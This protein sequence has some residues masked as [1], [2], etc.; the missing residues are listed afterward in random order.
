MP[1]DTASYILGQ[2]AGGGGGSDVT[3]EALDVTEN[4]TTT[5]PSG[6]AY[7]PVT[8]NVPNSYGAGDEGKVVSNG[9]LVAQ[10]AH[11]EVT[12][13]GT[14]DTTLNNSVTVNVSDGVD[15]A[16]EKDVNFIDY[17]GTLLYSYT[18]AEAQALTAL[19]A[20][21]SHSGLTAQGWNWTLQEIKAQ[22]T[23]VPGGP[24]WVGQMYVTT[25]GAT[26]IDIT[27]QSDA[28]L[29]YLQIGVNGTTT[30]DWGD[31]SNRDTVSGTGV[32]TIQ[33][34]PH[35]YARAGNYT[36]SIS[37]GS[38]KL[39]SG[40]GMAGVLGIGSDALHKS[41]KYSSCITG[42]RT[43][44]ASEASFTNYALQFCTSMRYVTLPNNTNIPQAFVGDCF[45]IRALVCPAS[46]TGANYGRFNR[47]LHRISFG[48]ALTMWGN[49]FC[50][51]TDSL[52]SIT[53]PS[54]TTAI[55]QSCFFSATSLVRVFIPSGV[56]AIGSGAFSTCSSLEEVHLLPTTPPALDNTNAFN[57]IQDYCKI[58]VPYSADHSILATYQTASN[59]S[60]YA[61]YMQEE[62]Q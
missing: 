18:A 13:N 53:I 29:P 47:S 14:I 40:S 39:Q 41:R 9:E 25:S 33:Y 6:K 16:P 22:L 24:V 8:V 54:G 11:A 35:T 49:Q 42:I 31:G 20:N 1:Y 10:T 57:N 17:D 3:V 26:E 23:A 60:T 32:N 58:Y 52:E 21:P 15:K 48:A 30:I 12:Q 61:S 37:G 5:A 51:N 59:W 44:S 27:L 19:P 36:I 43:G 56:T 7:S 50:Q 45:S 38:Y 55:A 34:I 46:F 28:L 4:G 62:P 2:R